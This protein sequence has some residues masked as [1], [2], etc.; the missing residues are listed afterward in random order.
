MPPGWAGTRA[1][2]LLEEPRCRWCGQPSTEVDHIINRARGGTDARSNLA[3][4]CRNCHA[5][6]SHEEA[7]AAR[8]AA[9]ARRRRRRTG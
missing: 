1:K 7:K 9:A 8:K 5:K 6:K 2:V 3:G 4:M